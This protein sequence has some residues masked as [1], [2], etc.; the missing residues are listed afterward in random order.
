MLLDLF[1]VTTDYILKGDD[2]LIRISPSSG[3]IPYIEIKA[4]AGYIKN[5][6]G[7]LSA[8]GYEW[9]RIP[10][11]NPSKDHRLFEIDG[12]SMAPTVF[13]NDIVIVQKQN[14]WDHILD[15]SLVIVATKKSLLAKRFKKGRN[16][17]SFHF[18]N[19]NP[20]EV[21]VLEFS[22][23]D[24]QEILIVRGKITNILFSP[25]HFAS[26]DK[27]K[28]MEESIEFLKKE[29]FIMSKKLASN[30]N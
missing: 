25:H 23:D 24:I 5:K 6:K 20:E 4:H 21:E 17:D 1:Q 27:I 16:P 10:G 7:D 14:N 30:R 12:E 15:G 26:S 13:P 2:T 19:D 11:Y 28:S 3:F 9:F 8:E 18:E 22:K 29:L